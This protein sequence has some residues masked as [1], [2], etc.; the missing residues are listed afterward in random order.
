MTAGFQGSPV[1]ID[2]NAVPEDP[3]LVEQDRLESKYREFLHF[4][5][6]FYI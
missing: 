6:P 5:I 3:V 2:A 4:S 1:S